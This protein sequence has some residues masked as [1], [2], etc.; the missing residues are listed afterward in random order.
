MSVNLTYLSRDALGRFG[1]VFRRWSG[2]G[3]F[4]AALLGFGVG[5][6]HRVAQGHADLGVERHVVAVAAE[7]GHLF[8]LLD[9]PVG[10]FHQFL[11]ANPAEA[12]GE[13]AEELHQLG[14]EAD[15]FEQLAP[16]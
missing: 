2:V 15:G 12:T 1:V 3:H 14:S 9:A 6:L 13:I 5:F 10:I 16:R 8:G 7:H 11:Q 4:A